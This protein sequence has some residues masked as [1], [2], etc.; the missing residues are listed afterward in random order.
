M[1]KYPMKCVIISIVTFLASLALSSLNAS[2]I[3]RTEWYIDAA[4]GDDANGVGSPELPFKSIDKLFALNDL[5]PGLVDSGDIIHLA[6][7]DY[8][9]NQLTEIS[10][11]GVEINGSLD[12]D[13][14]LVSVL[15]DLKIT[16]DDVVVINCIFVNASLTL[17]NVERASIFGNLFTGTTKYSLVLAGASRNM[18]SQNFF[19]SAEQSSLF[20]KVDPKSKKVSD[21]NIFYENV[22]THPQEYASR[23]AILVERAKKQKWSA[24]NYFIPVSYTHLTLPTTSRV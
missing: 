9:K 16:A 1:I 12:D 21:E 8:S 17:Q 4:N 7:G 13:G 14:K 3:D 24:R 6:A 11:P 20:I 18:I 23:R 19:G 15:G 10:T 2:L 22:F 5:L